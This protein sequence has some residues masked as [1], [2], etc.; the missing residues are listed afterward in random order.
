MLDT[1]TRVCLFFFWT[2]GYGLM[3]SIYPVVD[4]FLC[5]AKE[6]RA[7]HRQAGRQSLFGCYL[8]KPA[9]SEPKPIICLR[10]VWLLP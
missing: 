3:A 9:W 10:R 6:E 7:R 2:E 5:T 8:S 4:C 1:K